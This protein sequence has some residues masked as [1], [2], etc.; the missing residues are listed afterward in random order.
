MADKIEIPLQEIEK[1]IGEFIWFERGDQKSIPKKLHKC[2]D[3]LP[4]SFDD[5]YYHVWF[6]QED[7]K[8]TKI[9]TYG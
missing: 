6:T 7:F 9:F 4:A 1:H 2:A 3:G 8:E 5:G